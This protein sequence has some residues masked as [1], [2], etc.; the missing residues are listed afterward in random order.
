MNRERVLTGEKWSQS[1]LQAIINTLNKEEMDF[2]QAVWDYF[3]TFRP[4]MAEKERRITGVEPEWVQATPVLTQHGVYKGGYYPIAYDP[5]R[6]SKSAADV[7]SEVQRQM[8]RGLYTRAVTRRGH[9]KARS[10][11]T[12]RPM[13]YDLGVVTQHVGQVIHDL[14]WH[15]WLVD[16]NRLLRAS[17]IDQA[18]REHYKPEMLT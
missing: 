16:A 18:I 9:L 15:E 17:P 6:S 3:D 1:Q 14:A 2:V 10:E 5:L 11:S 4:Q 7:E 8:S 13:R 12:G